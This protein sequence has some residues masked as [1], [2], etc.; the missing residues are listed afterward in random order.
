[1]DNLIPLPLG[2]RD[3][4]LSTLANGVNISK[5]GCKFMTKGVLDVNCLKGSLMLLPV[6]ND[7]NTTPV[8]ST[9]HHDNIS[10]IKL[11]KLGDLVGL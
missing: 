1:M 3:P 8:S 11:D 2:E 6:L 5:S 4:W 9:G 7:S 10:N